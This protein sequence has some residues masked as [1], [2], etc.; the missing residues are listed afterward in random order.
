MK[1]YKQFKEDR[2]TSDTITKRWVD[3]DGVTRTRK[4]H[5][6]FVDFKNSKEGGE[7][8]QQDAPPK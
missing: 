8:S 4:V 5:P 6:H 7:P 1:T 3:R 2:A